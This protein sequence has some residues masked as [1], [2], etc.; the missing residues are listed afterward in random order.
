MGTESTVREQDR[1]MGEEAKRKLSETKKANRKIIE[2][3]MRANESLRDTYELQQFKLNSTIVE[4]WN[5]SKAGLT[6]YAEE[7]WER[8]TRN[9]P[10]QMLDDFT[11]GIISKPQLNEFRVALIHGMVEAFLQTEYVFSDPIGRFLVELGGATG[12]MILAPSLTIDIVFYLNEKILGQ[13]LCDDNNY[14]V[15]TRFLE[16]VLGITITKGDKKPKEY[17]CIEKLKKSHVLF[18]HYFG[19]K[20]SQ[21]IAIAK[22]GKFGNSKKRRPLIRPTWTRKTIKKMGIWTPLYFFQV[23]CHDEF[24]RF[25]F[26]SR[27]SLPKR[28]YFK[29]SGRVIDTNNDVAHAKQLMGMVDNRQSKVE[30]LYLYYYLDHYYRFIETAYLE[31]FEE[32]YNF[33]DNVLDAIKVNIVDTQGIALRQFYLNTLN[34]IMEKRDKRLLYHNCVERLIEDKRDKLNSV[35][36]VGRN[37]NSY[38][39][40][41]D[42]AI[43]I[44]VNSL[45]L[46]NI[47]IKLVALSLP[48]FKEVEK[49]YGRNRNILLDIAPEDTREIFEILCR[50]KILDYYFDMHTGDCVLNKLSNKSSII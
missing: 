16:D 1:P 25:A 32:R 18:A 10:Q 20:Q 6:N 22:F 45:D 13:S 31:Y 3:A 27:T 14:G 11:R 44:F 37:I 41:R 19:S 38:S 17:N 43:P 50:Q 47:P 39:N 9:I 23:G 30:K 40:N 28:I 2:A 4:T 42:I 29:N 26:H 34:S 33:S 35:F 5:L 48:V 21:L 36:G 12:A 24:M 46:N 15:T 49:R 7:T 8:A